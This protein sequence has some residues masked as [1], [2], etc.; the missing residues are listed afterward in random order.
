MNS[1]GGRD[2]WDEE[3][4][5]KRKQKQEQEKRQTIITDKTMWKNGT[6]EKS[7][8]TGPADRGA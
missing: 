4:K 2:V 5:E 6:E 3:Q 8:G 7:E 1:R